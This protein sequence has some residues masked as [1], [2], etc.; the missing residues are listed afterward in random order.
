M[1][2]LRKTKSKMLR[3]ALGLVVVG[4]WANTVFGLQVVRDQFCNLRKKIKIELN[5]EGERKERRRNDEQR[6]D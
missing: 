2:V 1:I 5:R 6:V 4:P 3:L